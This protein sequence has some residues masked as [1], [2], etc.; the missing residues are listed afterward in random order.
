LFLNNE[1][2]DFSMKPGVPNGYGLV[3]ADA[4]AIAPGKRMLSSMTPSF[5][6]TQDRVMVVGSPGGSF[7]IGMVLL[8]TLD[9]IEGRDAKAIVS[10]PRIHHQYLPDVVRFEPDALDAAQRQGLEQRGHRLEGGNRRWG[11]L[12]VVIWNRQSGVLE[13]AADPRG[14]GA[15]VVE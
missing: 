8:A 7:I 2:D 12:Q 15:G 9:F 10:A 11:N 1:M 13:A 14:D 6:E 4:N 5:I 3:G